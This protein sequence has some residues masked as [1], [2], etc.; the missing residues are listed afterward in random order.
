[1]PAPATVSVVVHGGDRSSNSVDPPCLE[2]AG[3]GRTVHCAGAIPGDRRSFQFERI[4]G[5]TSRP[6]DDSGALVRDSVAQAMGGGRAVIAA[7]GP[8]GGGKTRTMGLLPPFGC[9]GVLQAVF[10][11][12]FA[13][14]DRRGDAVTRPRI[15]V[16]FVEID[17]NRLLDLIGSAEREEQTEAASAQPVSLG[18]DD[19]AGADARTQEL[20]ADEETRE[21]QAA[22]LIERACQARRHTALGGSPSHSLSH[23]VVSIALESPDGAADGGGGRRRLGCI[24]LLD[25]CPVGA[26]VHGHDPEAQADRAL[27]GLRTLTHN[28]APLASDGSSAHLPDLHD[29]GYVWTSRLFRAALAAHARLHVLVCVRADADAGAETSTVLDY[30]A[31]CQQM[32]AAAFISTEEAE[33]SSG[34][35]DASLLAG[36]YAAIAPAVGMSAEAAAGGADALESRGAFLLRNFLQRIVR[37]FSSRKKHAPNRSLLCPWMPQSL[38]QGSTEHSLALLS[39][40]VQ[41]RVAVRACYAQ[42]CVRRPHRSSRGS[43]QRTRP[44]S[45][46]RNSRNSASTSSMPSCRSLMRN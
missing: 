23:T 35:D 13:A 41:G 27:C 17:G 34:D 19:L 33:P 43:R 26:T 45:S 20:S 11:C 7:I 6:E 18:F 2:L 16:S 29:R 44:L 25:L 4:I 40:V 5:D 36:V 3:D 39:S 28:L 1:M 21:E 31:R 14:L 15:G 10:R 32:N 46:A 30:A 22:A 8:V 12:L 42:P 24:Q 9:D 38:Q 37:R